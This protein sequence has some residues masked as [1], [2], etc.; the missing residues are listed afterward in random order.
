M[1]IRR[2][3][4]KGLPNSREY[5]RFGWRAAGF[6]VARRVGCFREFHL[7]R[8]RGGGLVATAEAE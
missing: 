1:A 7:P 8:E 4:G 5:A 6:I 3:G 2:H